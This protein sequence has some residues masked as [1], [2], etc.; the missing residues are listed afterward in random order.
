MHSNIDSC[1]ITKR[2][3]GIHKK[4]ERIGK[5]ISGAGG[6]AQYVPLFSLQTAS[7]YLNFSFLIQHGLT[8]YRR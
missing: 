8:H 6:G 1:L 5:Q 7:E 4:S 3:N 2:L